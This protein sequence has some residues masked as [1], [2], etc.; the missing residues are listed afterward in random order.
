MKALISIVLGLGLMVGCDM[1]TGTQS[2]TPPTPTPEP[3]IVKADV[4][5]SETSITVINADKKNWPPQRVFLNGTPFFTFGTVIPGLRPGQ[6]FTVALRDFVKDDGERF[7][8]YRMKVVK[9][10]IGGGGG[11]DYCGFEN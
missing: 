6:K 3:K 1:Q 8:P 2:A 10:M 11:Y 9:V 4:R 7:D 5:I